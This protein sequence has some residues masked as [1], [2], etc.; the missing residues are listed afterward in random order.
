MIVVKEVKLC[1]STNIEAISVAREEDYYEEK[2]N[3]DSTSYDNSGQF[4]E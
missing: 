1:Y 2:T 3:N 4:D